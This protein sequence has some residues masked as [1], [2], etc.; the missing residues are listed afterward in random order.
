VSRSIRNLLLLALLFITQ[1]TQASSALITNLKAGKP[2]TVVAYGTSLTAGGK[3]VSDLQDWLNL[4]YP[5]LATVINSG[6]GG[7]ASNTGVNLLQ[8][9]VIS[10]KPDTVFIEFS[11]NDAFTD[12]SES[13]NPIDF[14]PKITLERA[15]ANLMTMITTIRA[16]NPAAEII[17]M[18]MNVAY[19]SAKNPTAATNRPQLDAYYQVYRDV[20][21]AEGL[22]CI[23]H[24]ANWK[25]LYDGNRTLFK[26]YVP[27]GL[28]PTAAGSTAVTTPAIQ[29]ALLEPR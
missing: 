23:D 16:A 9:K 24:Y 1:E 13:K 20:A 12:F 2:Q 5:G 28:H 18:T 22:L 19:D 25:E 10:K 15:R 29:S 6:Q 26:T 17:L 8:A 7:K 11:M 4:Q 14:D 3:W 27:D 21:A